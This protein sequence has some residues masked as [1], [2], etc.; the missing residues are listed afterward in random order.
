VAAVREALLMVDFDG[1]MSDIFMHRYLFS[2]R[3]SGQGW[4]GGNDAKRARV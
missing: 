4:I 1:R 2:Q 3:L